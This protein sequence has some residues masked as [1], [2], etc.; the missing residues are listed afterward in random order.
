MNIGI[1]TGCLYPMLTED[2]I[3]TLAQ[4]GFDTVEIFFN[5]FSELEYDYI[6]RIKNILDAYGTKVKSIHPFTSAFES[7]LLFSNYERRFFDG[8]NMYEMYFRTAQRLGAEKVVLHGL[9]TMYPSS[10][11]DSEYFRRF[12]IMQKRAECYGVKLL[13]E[14]VNLFRSNDINFIERMIAEIPES[15]GFVCDIKQAKRGGT[16]P[17]DMIKTMGKYLRHIH[18]ND[19]SKDNQ[20][21]LPG[22]GC[23]D[24]G[25]FFE[26]VRNTGYDGDVIIEVYRFSFGELEELKESFRFLNSFC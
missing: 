16:E 15:A 19:F 6:G 20:C 21:V 25:K 11:S 12:E 22:K 26:E 4:S 13:Q 24:F 3:K 9:T 7:F 1:S 14:N 17:A 10:L 2:C 5:T 8:V 18:I 23:F